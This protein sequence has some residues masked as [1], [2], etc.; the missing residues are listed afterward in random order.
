MNRENDENPENSNM[1]AIIERI[2]D[3]IKDYE[4]YSFSDQQ[5]CA[6]KTFFDLAQEFEDQSDFYEICVLIPKVFFKFECNLYLLNEAE[7]FELVNSS[8]PSKYDFQ[9]TV[10]YESEY[11]DGQSVKN[12]CFIIPIKGNMQL[13]SSLSDSYKSGI[14]GIYEIHPASVI[15]DHMKL[16]FEKYVNRI[17]FQLHNKF[18]TEKNR[19]HLQFIQNLVNDIGH[20]VIVPNM[21]FKLFF[22]RLKGKIDRANA[23]SGEMLAYTKNAN[24]GKNVP[25][26]NESLILANEL[27]YVNR[28]MEAQFQEILSHYEQTSLFLETL[29]RRSHFEEGRYVIEPKIFNFKEKIIRPQLERYAPSLEDRGVLI[30]NQLSGIPGEEITVAADVGLISQAYANLFSNAV[31]YTREIQDDEGNPRKFVTVGMEVLIDYFGAEKDGIKFNVFSTGLH[32]L[33][34]DVPKL[35]DEGY[36]GKN[37][38]SEYGTGH[39]LQFIKEVIDLHGGMAGYEATPYGNNFFFILPK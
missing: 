32:I 16:F 17:G 14:L 3:K 5:D 37:I 1:S 29:L 15:S 19:E 36:R 23:I 33:S 35:F 24:S 2:S 8:D 28:S 20:N 13:L 21:Y 10:C 22:K 27:R 31:K 4:K 26:S 30:D 18:I 38:E 9:K 25:G 39:G 12:D 6:L 34:E 7:R 11:V